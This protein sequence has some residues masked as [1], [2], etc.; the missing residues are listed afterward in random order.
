MR[1]VAVVGT[2]I[3]RFGRFPDASLKTLSRGVIAAVLEDA[4][5]RARD[6]DSVF[7]ANAVAGVV[8]GQ[9]MIRGQVALRDTALAGA[10]I[11]NVENACAS[12]GSAFHLAWLAVASGRSDCVLVVGA[13]RLTH[14]DKR[15]SFDALARGVDLDEPRPASSGGGP[16][17]MEIYAAKAR[18]WMHETGVTREDLAHV[19]VK[20]RMAAARNPDAQFREPTTVEAVLGSRPVADPLTVPMC[21]GIGDGAAALMLCS[22]GTVRRLGARPVWV[23]ACEVVSALPDPGSPICA[24]RAARAAYERSGIGPGELH[25]VELHDAS[26]PAELMHYE[27]LGL[28]GRG[29][30]GALLR[31]GATALGGRVPVNP[32]GGL[33]SRGHPIGATGAA[34]IVEVARQL[35]GDAGERQRPGARVGLA[36]NNGGQ[37]GHDAAV[38]VATLLVA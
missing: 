7:F 6:V 23:K 31:S 37:I 8:T 16:I 19:V 1:P 32:S 29:E 25:V 18:A 24:V 13:E 35:R 17:F 12:G 38:A 11:F 21:S 9:E 15:V 36:E 30:A 34:Q 3:T 27:N 22:A 14:H 20:S 28:C 10:P 4:G 26:A 2:G 5:A 33:L